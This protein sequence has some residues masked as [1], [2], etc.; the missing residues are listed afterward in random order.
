MEKIYDVIIVG[1]GPAGMFAAL[2]LVNLDPSLKICILEKGSVRKPEHRIQKEYSTCGWGGA[3]TFS[4]GKLNLT[5]KSGGQL[6]E[7][8]TEEEFALLMNYVDERY[9]EFG[10]ADGDLKTPDENK[11]R[12]LK[13]EIMAA[14]FQDFIY[15]PTRHWGTDNA[16]NIVGNIRQSLLGSGVDIACETEMVD[17]ARQQSLFSLKT[18]Q[19]QIFPAKVCILA[20]GRGSNEQT[21]NIARNFNLAVKSNGVDIGV[22]VETLS[23]SFGNITDVAHSPKLVFRSS[24]DD[25]VRTF[26]VCP[27]GFVKLESSYGILTVNGE[28]YSEKSGIKSPNTNFAILVHQ[29]F[30]EPF[31]DPIGYGN[32]IASLAN[33]LGKTVIIQTLRNLLE[34][35]RSTPERL[36]RNAVKPT[37]KDAVAGDLNLVIPYKFMLAI[38]EKF[39]ALM[40]VSA[41]NIDNTVCYGVEVKQYA[42]KVVTDKN[43]QSAIPGLYFIGDGGGSTRGILQASM[44]GILAAWHIV[45]MEI[46]KKAFARC[47]KKE[48]R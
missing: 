13:M 17:I 31:D 32:K 24:L 25:E 30:T 20:G 21:S 48:R 16:Y 39:Q 41:I 3:G 23:E 22:R 8:L 1:S 10:G 14:G 45:N 43:G 15:Y 36:K 7:V 9:C 18:K 33:D 26:C 40:R 5:S 19:G 44:Q 34:G 42:K 12:Q 2:E 27:R 37:L 29:D 4:D 6:D 38:K 47:L 35:R 28:S 46:K 11:A